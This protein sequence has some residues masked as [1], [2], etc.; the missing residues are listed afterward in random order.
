MPLECQVH[1]GFGSAAAMRVFAAHPIT[2]R[3]GSRCL[4]GA[5]PPSR[6][7]SGII[8]H[9]A[10][11]FART[12]AFRSGGAPRQVLRLF[13]NP[14]ETRDPNGLGTSTLEDLHAGRGSRPARQNVIHQQDVCSIEV[15]FCLR[16]DR[17][18]S[19][20]DFLSRLRPQAAERGRRFRPHQRI[21]NQ[22]PVTELLQLPPQ[23]CCLVQ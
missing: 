13:Q 18:R 3:D 5:A 12:R 10:P 17:N 7:R 11:G 8:R 23:Q 2:M 9:V 1:G 19:G 6:D 20:E 22:F 4:L 21:D 16:V 14:R 15:R